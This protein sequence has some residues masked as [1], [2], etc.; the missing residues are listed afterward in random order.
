[1]RGAERDHRGL[2]DA[3]A[4]D[5]NGAD[6]RERRAIVGAALDPR[7]PGM[8]ALDGRAADHH[9]VGK[10]QRLGANRAVE[11]GGKVLDGGP[12]HAIVRAETARGGPVIRMR[13]ELVIE[14]QPSIG[15]VEEYRVEGRD[16]R[17]ARQFD[18]RRPVSAVRREDQI[19]TSG[20]PSA[21]P[22]NHAASRSPFFSSTTVE[23]V[24]GAERCGIENELELRR[25]A[26][27]SGRGEQQDRARRQL[28]VQPLRKAGRR[29]LFASALLVKRPFAASHSSLPSTR[30]AMTPSSIH[31]TNGADT[32]KFEQAGSPPLQ[33]RI[34]S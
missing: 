16:L 22:P 17:L 28:S 29:Y 31:S 4:R 25:G 27:R 23:C 13:A 11:A 34:Q 32:L 6:A 20:L 1:M 21:V 18:G 10:Y 5:R 19:A 26:Q 33:A 3:F 30:S 2:D 24:A 14:P 7:R 15:R 8:V 12:G 9:T